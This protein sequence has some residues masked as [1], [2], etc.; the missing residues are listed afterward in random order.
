MFRRFGAIA[1][2]V[3]ASLAFAASAH[4]APSTPTLKPL[5]AYVCGSS[6][7]LSWAASTP[8]PGGVIVQYRVDVGDLTA[9]T[10]G[11]KW[12]PGTS[13]TIGGPIHHHHSVVRVRALQWRAGALTWSATSART[14]YAACLLID[15][16]RLAQYVEY[17]PWPGCIMC[18]G[19]ESM[20][21]DDPVIRKEISVAT[22]PGPERIKGL[23]LE[24]DGSVLIM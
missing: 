17:N 20:Q 6:V 4:A 8:D 5:P 24:A 22:L 16:A 15:P 11:F 2:A 7:N 21:I 3:A 9:G 13:T 1:G 19:L 23:E 12:V 14:F 18:G 10:A